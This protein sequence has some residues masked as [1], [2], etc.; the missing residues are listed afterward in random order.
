[1]KHLLLSSLLLLLSYCGNKEINEN[2]ITLVFRGVAGLVGGKVEGI[3]P[4]WDLIKEIVE[5][6]MPGTTLKLSPIF[7]PEGE[8]FTKLAISLRND[9]SYDIISEDSFIL[10]S[11]VTAGLL[12]PLAVE[13]W[14]DWTNFYESSHNSATINGKVYTIP[15]NT[16]ARGLF[17][18]K[19]LFA[20]ADIPSNWQPTS[21]ND[22]L[23]TARKIK[24]LNSPENIQI[25]KAALSRVY[26]EA[27]TMQTFLMLLYG[28]EDQLYE[29][30]KWV[31]DSKG[32]YDTLFFLQ[33]LRQENLVLGNEYLLT[34]TEGPYSLPM[35]IEGNNG[36]RFDGSWTSGS[37][38]SV[39]MTN[40]RDIYGFTYFP[41][42]YGN[43]NRPMIT[44]QGGFG[45]SISANSR[46]KEK[47]WE[48]IKL[49]TSYNSLK[50]IYPI[51]GHLSTRK[52]VAQD[53]NYQKIGLNKEATELVSYGFYRPANNEYPAV[54][55]EIQVLVENIM[56]NMDIKKAISIFANNIEAI[57][58]KEKTIRKIY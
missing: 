57:V 22:I 35:I 40:W 30:G 2:E 24:N 19:K 37:F 51:S 1:M 27:T 49:I 6:E 10:Q 47:A 32:L 38:L 25:I 58:G 16:D 26:G 14:E 36:I 29:N 52:D 21:W 20:Q 48:I 15:W 39:G 23:S 50:E 31:V 33:T 43:S 8:Y 45:F 54:S 28:T 4:D 11:D 46:R 12:S 5:R 7:A 44:F 41:T 34:T 53:T 9:V 3:G 13:D 55:T 17:Y 56:L 18:S 42:Q